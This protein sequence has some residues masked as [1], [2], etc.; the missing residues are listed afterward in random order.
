[1][2]LIT[3]STWGYFYIWCLD[4]PLGNTKN[5][6]A[7]ARHYAGWCLDIEARTEAHQA[8]RGA[9]LTAAVVARKIPYVIYSWPA[10]LATEKQV[11]AH[12]NTAHYCPR[13]AARAGRVPLA[14]PTAQQLQLDL[15]QPLDL[16]PLDVLGDFPAPPARAIDWFEVSTL[17]RWRLAST[18]PAQPAPDWDFGLL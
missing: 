14:I 9:R 13:C 12:K 1:M 16:D 5:R 2:T 18:A 3:A 11:K 8:G 15:R 10:P 6:R 7:Q 4:R 17:K